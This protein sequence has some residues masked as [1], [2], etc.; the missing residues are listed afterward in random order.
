MKTQA[1]SPGSF[2]T[3]CVAGLEVDHPQAPVAEHAA[4]ERVDAAVVGAAVT[5]ASII[6][7]TS[8]GSGGAC[9]DTRPAMPHIWATRY[10]VVSCHVERPLDDRV[11]ARFSRLQAARPGGFRIA[12]LMRPP[13]PETGED[14]TIW[15]ERA[16]TA[17]AHGP[18]GHHTHWTSPT[19]ARPT[20]RRRRRARAPRRRVAAG[21]GPPPHALLRRRLVHGRVGRRA[22]SPSSATPTAPRRASDPRTST[23]GRRGSRSMHPDGSRFPTGGELL[24]L[25]TTH[26]LGMAARAAL[27]RR[28]SAEPV[29]HVYFHD[30]DLLDRRRA[31]RS[32]SRSR[33]SAAAGPPPTSI[34]SPS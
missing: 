5:S 30:T 6:R 25:P 32:A 15:L 27:S 2:A 7:S 29:V 20:R 1:T 26:S 12:A 34:G 13:D 9:R 31:P 19:H 4:A 24:E 16:R 11:W 33:C 8:A 3:G 18:L 22:P 17:A 10:A 28:G 23:T 14:E 21:A